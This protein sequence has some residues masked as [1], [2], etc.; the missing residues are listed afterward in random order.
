MSRKTIIRLIS[1]NCIPE[2]VF[3]KIRLNDSPEKILKRANWNHKKNWKLKN[4]KRRD[5]RNYSFFSEKK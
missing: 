1:Q 5:I 2:G 3:P 4:S